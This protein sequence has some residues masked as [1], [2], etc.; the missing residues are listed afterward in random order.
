MLYDI[1][2]DTVIPH[3]VLTDEEGKKVQDLVSSSRS[4][5]KHD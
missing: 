3:K 2:K 1:S 4:K 5:F